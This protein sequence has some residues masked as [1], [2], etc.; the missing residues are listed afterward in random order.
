MSHYYRIQR[1]GFLTPFLIMA[2]ALSLRAQSQMTTGTIEGTVLD[3]S[4]AVV[5]GASVVLTHVSTG[6]SRTVTT[7]E[8]GRYTAPLL[9]VGNYEITVQMAGFSTVRR[10]GVTLTLGQTQVIDV[11]LKV[12][13][14]EQTVEVVETAPL[15]ETSKS[16]TSATVDVSQVEGLPINGR[17]FF[18]LAFLTPGIYQEKERNQLS[19]AGARG[20]NSNINIDGADFNQ[21]FFGGQRGGERSNDAYVVSQEAIREFQVVRGN[22]SAEFGRSTGGVMNVITK[23]GTNEYHGSAFYFLRHRE[24]APKDIRGENRA[25]TRH[26]FGGGVGGPIIKNRTFFYNVYDQQDQSQ[27]LIVRFNTTAGLPQNLISQQGDFTTTNDVHTYLVKIDHQL[28]PSHQLLGRYNY[29]RNEGVNGTFTGRTSGVLEN[30]GTEKDR[31][32]TGVVNL[33]SVL[34]PTML[35]EFRWQYSYEER[36]RLNNTEPPDFQNTAGPQVQVSGCCFFGGVSFLP[37]QQ[38]DDRWQFTDNFSLIKGAHNIKLGFD[39]NRSYVDQIFRGNW[40]GVYVFNNIGNFVRALNQEINPAT[41]QPYTADQ[42]RAFFGSGK[43]QASVKE[44]ATYAQDTMRLSSHLTLNVG[45]RYEAFIMPQPIS[46]NPLLPQTASIP[47]DKEMW[48]PRFGLTWDFLGTGKTV[49]RVGG[50][51]F[52]ARTPLLLMNQA[53]NSN[54]SPNVGVSFTLNASQIAAVQRVHPEFV[55]PFVPDTSQSSNSS[56]IT[57]AGIAGLRPD[58]S[59]FAP[60]FRNPRSLQYTASLDHQLSNNLAVALDYVHNNTVYLERIR[61]VNLAPP[62]YSLDNS[63]PPVSRPRFTSPRPNPAFNILRQQESSAQSNYDA[64]T[65]TLKRRY[66]SRLQFY[67]NYTLAYSRSD[68]DNERNFAGIAY[69][70][71]FN[72]QDEY[73]WSRNDIRHRW[74]AS[75]LYDLPLGFQ[76]GSIVEWRTG[77][78]FSA[79]TG[80]DSNLDNQF[81]DKPVIGGRPLLRNSFR[82]PNHFNHDLRVSKSFSLFETQKLTWIFEMFNLWNL[83]NLSYNVSTNESSTTALGSRWGTSQTP[84]PT[85]RT[86]YLANGTLNSGGVNV[87]SPFQLQVALKYTF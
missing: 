72:L 78:P 87:G 18:D 31:T 26:Q 58:A 19:L 36:P 25:P 45:F 74:V 59:F 69:E 84:L 61:D 20:I 46:P 51:L 70:N 63:V 62:V 86:L 40:R 35:N 75:G 39:F 4:G 60:D 77:S 9:S 1:V 79:F 24:F 81:T 47:S 28:S 85:F 5:A 43:F 41:N 44:Y 12:A 83:D 55:F 6:I 76:V 27:P 38:Y 34:S 65:L 14:V 53:F 11:S 73:R 2:L 56:Y 37:I 21:P 66:A 50:G 42:F 64:L 29:S 80:T 57:G 7:G 67:T 15:I 16:E 30:N 8:N 23:S 10:T 48:Q 32:H 52:H 68:D 54:G 3:E 71:A 49:L 17:R 82:Q 13:A 22:F 33:N